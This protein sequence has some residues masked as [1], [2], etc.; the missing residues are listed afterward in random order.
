M[1]YAGNPGDLEHVALRGWVAESDH[2]TLVLQSFAWPGS[3]GS[4]VFDIAG[5]AI[6]V[7][8][9]IPIV[10]NFWEGGMI[11]LSQIVLVRRLEVLPRKTIREA[12]KDEKRRT[13]S[14]NAD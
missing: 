7:V 10:H 14:R 2:K 3:S 9:A 6:G 4:I 11:P 1:Y 12:L 5:R 8:S 13:E